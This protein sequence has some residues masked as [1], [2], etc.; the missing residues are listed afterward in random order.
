MD[1]KEINSTGLTLN[2]LFWIGGIFMVL[3]AALLAHFVWRVI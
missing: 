3:L 2:F 1:K